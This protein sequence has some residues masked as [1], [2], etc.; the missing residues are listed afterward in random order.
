[1]NPLRIK[2]GENIAF[3]T[4]RLDLKAL[5]DH[6]RKGYSLQRDSDNFKPTPPGFSVKDVKTRIN[7]GND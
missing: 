1:M 5:R 2:G 3:L 6:Q 7:F 4:M